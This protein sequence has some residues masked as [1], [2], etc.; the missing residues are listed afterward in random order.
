MKGT[1]I[2]KQSKT[3]RSA[4]K[5]HSTTLIT[6]DGKFDS[7]RELKRWL[8]LKDMQSLKL[9]SGLQRQVT[10][11]LIPAQKLD[12]P[13]VHKGRTQRTELAVKYIADF[14][15][16]EDGKTVVEDAKGLRTDTYII[17]RKLMKY[18]HGI[19]IVEV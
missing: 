6:E 7:K 5:Y 12:S 9:I 15:Y 17:K 3:G 16:E 19:E 4:S 13:R 14:V 11:E 18:I 8:V 2:L 1:R 10:Y